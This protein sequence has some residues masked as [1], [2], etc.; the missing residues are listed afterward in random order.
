[1]IKKMFTASMLAILFGMSVLPAPVSAGPAGSWT[2]VAPMPTAREMLAAATG[3]DGRIYA[4]GGAYFDHAVFVALNT[5]EAYAPSTDSWAT[6]APL[7]LPLYG[8]AAA[9]GTDGR[10]YVMGGITS[11]VDNGVHTSAYT[12]AAEAYTPSTDSWAPVAPLPSPLSGM[13]AATG[14]DG[15]IYVI[16]GTTSPGQ[17]TNAVEAYTPS[18]NSWTTVA[19]LPRPASPYNYS[20]AATAGQDGRIYVIAGGTN[21]VEVYTPGTNSWTTVAPLPSAMN[22]V[23]AAVTVSDGR[24]YAMGDVYNFGNLVQVYTP[25]TNSWTTV[26]SL[27]TAQNGPAAATGPDGRIYAIGGIGPI[28]D[29][30]I[31]LVEAYT[32]SPPPSIGLSSLTGVPFQTIT[33]TGATFGASEPVQVLWDSGTTLTTT[34][35]LAT[36]SFTT[37][38]K[39]PQAPVGTHTVMVVGETSTLQVSVSFQLK[40][41]LLLSPNSGHAGSTA[42]GSAYGFGGQEPVV[43]YWD[44]P[45]QVAGAGTTNSQGNLVTSVRIPANATMGRHRVYALGQN[46]HAITF[47]LF[48]VR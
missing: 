6:I 48:T 30:V 35:T 10:I 18:T 1:M 12:N 41:L 20:I 17:A 9:T 43:L 14:S 47:S 19:P 46:S 40:P 11:T 4:I 13:A 21:T 16:G 2:S 42:V 22:Y 26:V 25:S 34:T 24:I 3:P 23:S 45:L 31:N 29:S 32:P 44:N 37:T 38:F 36:G 28:P 33:I 27:P 8:M 5:V 39:V 7:P 15:R